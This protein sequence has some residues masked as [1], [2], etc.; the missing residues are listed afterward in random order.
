MSRLELT[1]AELQERIARNQTR[2]LDSYYQIDEVYQSFDAR[3][4]GDKEGRALLA[5]VN[6][7]NM[8]GFENPCMQPFLEIYPQKANEKGYLGPVAEG[9]LFEQQLSGH[10]WLLRGLCAHYDRYAD[11]ASL[12]YAKEIVKGLFLPTRGCYS[13]YP[14]ERD[15]SAGGVS[16]DSV[17]ILNGWK[18]STDIGCAFMSIDGLS[19]YYAIT[20]EEAVK[21]LLDEMIEVYSAIDKEKLKAQTHCTLTAARGMVRMYQCH[22]EVQYLEKAKEIYNLYI[23]S[24]MTLVYQNFNWWG[25]RD[26]WTEPCAIVDSLLLA[27]ELYRITGE[28]SYRTMAARIFHNGFASS[29]RAN[30]GAGTDSPVSDIEPYLYQKKFE[31]Y[32]CCSMRLAEGLQYAK[33]HRE[34]LYA[35]TVGRIL[36]D[37]HG[38]YMDGDILYAK[39]ISSDGGEGELL[40][41]IKYFRTDTALTDTLRQQVIFK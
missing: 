32:F 15:N 39:A 41:L 10:S 22:G 1:L 35:E 33:D 13:S 27:G 23:T 40:P 21:E 38:R 5:F 16:G 14:T 18:I 19:H 26:S 4:P 11:D 36:R 17:G 31:A 6:H 9:Y 29:Q 34:E 37:E 20:K 2:L 24:G 12:A 3:W 7:A 25:R 30:G 8:T 28:K